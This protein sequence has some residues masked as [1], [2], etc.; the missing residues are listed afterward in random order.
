MSNADLLLGREP[1]ET[2][3][4]RKRQRASRA[5][6]PTEKQIA[7]AIKNRLALY[8]CLVQANPNEER[9]RSAGRAR[10]IENTILGFPDLTVIGPDG[11]VA[12][13]ELKRL[14]AKPSNDKARAH[15]ARQE[16]FRDTLRRMGHTAELVHS[17]DEA[18]DVLRAAG[19]PV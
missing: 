6:A 12:F 2:R 9:S 7:N 1:F 14:G 3:V 11:R 18:C 13:L 19:W 5:P 10:K 8:G 16:A 15:W 17:Q 4:P